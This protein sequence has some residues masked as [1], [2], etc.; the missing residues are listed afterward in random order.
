[1]C[2]SI[3]LNQFTAN[4]TGL[5]VIAGPID[6]TLIGNLLV[7]AVG[8]GALEWPQIR[9]VVRNSFELKLFQPRDEQ[10]WQQA[11][12]R[13]QNMLEQSAHGNPVIA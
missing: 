12:V 5:E 7:Q 2:S 3:L 8:M 13:F 9:E 6:A 4:A 11:F 1:M 10:H